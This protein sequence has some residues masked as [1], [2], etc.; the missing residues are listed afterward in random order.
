[1]TFLQIFFAPPD[2]LEHL[3]GGISEKGLAFYEALCQE[4]LANGV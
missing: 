3:R 1:M 2:S 4:V